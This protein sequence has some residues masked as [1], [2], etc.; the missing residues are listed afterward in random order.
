[1][2]PDGPAVASFERDGVDAVIRAWGDGASWAI[3]Q[4]PRLL[5]CEDDPTG[6]EPA[7]PLLAQAWRQHRW[8][9][10]GATGNIVEELAPAVL[11]QRVT[12]AEAFTS[13]S[14]LTRRYG[15]QSPPEWG[16]LRL[17]FPL[18]AA[19]WAAIPSWAY[20][21]AGVEQTRSRTLVGAARLNVQRIAHH[22]DPDAAL[23]SLPGIGVWTSARVR[24]VALG[25]PDAWSDGDYHIPRLIALALAGDPEADAA[26]VLAPYAGHRYRV[27]QLVGLSGFRLERHGPRRATPTHLP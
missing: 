6:F 13:Y 9:R 25:D 24:Q 14:R 27:E 15:T 8:L 5:G 11:E 10:V 2:T 12:G 3:D 20:L 7:H 1:M 23:R 26:A 21:K 4:A 18:T 19:Q 16:G 17:F 22:H